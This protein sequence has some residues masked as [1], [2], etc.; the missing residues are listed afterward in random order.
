MIVGGRL[1]SLESY[2]P[3]SD[4][5]RRAVIVICSPLQVSEFIRSRARLSMDGVPELVN[6]ILS[7]T[8]VIARYFIYAITAVMR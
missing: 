4:S 6:A 8:E 1:S 2:N 7:P 3:R 5:D